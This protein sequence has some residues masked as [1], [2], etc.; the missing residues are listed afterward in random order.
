MK[1]KHKEIK[2]VE[3]L[4]EHNRIRRMSDEELKDELIGGENETNI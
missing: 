3:E 2:I 1:T 4:N